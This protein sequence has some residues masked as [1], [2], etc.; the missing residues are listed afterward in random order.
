MG[1]PPRSPS[2]PLVC[3]PGVLPTLPPYPFRWILRFAQNDRGPCCDFERSQGSLRGRLRR[4]TQVVALAG[5][6]CQRGEEAFMK[7]SIIRISATRRPPSSAQLSNHMNS[8]FGVS[9]TCR[10]RPPP[11]QVLPAR[12]GPLTL[13][14]S[15]AP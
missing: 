14:T 3:R 9:P 1:L 13:R 11:L 5:A 12:K 15:I 10:R 8:V 2:P 7:R 4:A 6:S